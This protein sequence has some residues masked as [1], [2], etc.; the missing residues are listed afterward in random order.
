MTTRSRRNRR[1]A[2][3]GF[4]F[5]GLAA[6]GSSCPLGL[7][8]EALQ[9]LHD[10]GV[11]KYIGQFTPALSEDVGDGWTRHTFDTAG[12]NGP[13]CIAG[14]PFTVFTRPRDPDKV[15]IHL[16]GGGACWQDFYVCN[17]LSDSAPPTASPGASGIWVDSYDTGSEVIDNPLADWSVV[18]VPYCD[19]SVFSGDNVVEDDAFPFGDFRFHR[20]L[21]NLTAAMDVAKAAFPAPHKV[22]LAG[23]SAG[24]V[25]VAGF[26]PFIAR[27]LYG[28]LVQLFVF[29]DAGPVAVNL[30]ETAAIQARAADWQFG[31]FYPASCTECDDEGQATAIIQWRLDNDT[32]IREGF[33]STDGDATDRFFLNIPTQE[34]Y[35]ELILTEHG[36]LHDS[37]PLRYKRFIRSGDDEHTALQRPTFYEG[38]AN[39][40][41]LWFWTHA[42]VNNP[43]SLFW[44]D[45]VED[46]VPLP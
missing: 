31:Q 35:R 1:F 5:I 19:G 32:T 41:P 23:T 14:T 38:E 26:A 7:S 36:A 29:N 13:I 30:N 4:L 11:D 17:V 28:N 21:R 12:G 16:Q 24:G 37:A 33:Y 45:L 10:A 42:F 34:A 18:Y 9:E 2:I 22:L 46:F 27:F 15:L 25:G 6:L 43:A 44:I 3:L 20:G 40:F 8:P 39:G